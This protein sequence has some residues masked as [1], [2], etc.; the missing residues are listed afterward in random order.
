MLH[1]GICIE[2]LLLCFVTGA[3]ASSKCCYRPH[4]S[5]VL[6][7]PA[8]CCCY[9]VSCKQHK[10]SYLTVQ[11]KECRATQ[12]VPCKPGL[13]GALLPRRCE[14]V[15]PVTNQACPPNSWVV[16]GERS[17]YVDQQTLKLQVRFDS[18][19]A[20]FGFVC[21]PLQAAVARTNATQ[22]ASKTEKL[23][24]LPLLDCQ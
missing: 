2:V 11:C 15:D 9:D 1:N 12:V 7:A 3:V 13:G 10:A 24:L 23:Y 6:A 5:F 22:C 19:G 16:L 18:S 4:S 20:F 17:R 21:K 8:L 14:T